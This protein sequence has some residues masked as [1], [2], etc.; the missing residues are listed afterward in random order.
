MAR[1]KQAQQRSDSIAVGVLSAGKEEMIVGDDWRKIRLTI[2]G[3]TPTRNRK[4]YGV[5][6]AFIVDA[7]S[8]AFLWDMSLETCNYCLISVSTKVK[9]VESGCGHKAAPC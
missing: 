9:P 8:N 4:P 5:A 1:G 2:Q 7:I 3:Q 6:A